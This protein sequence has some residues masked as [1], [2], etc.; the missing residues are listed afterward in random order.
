MT[1]SGLVEELCGIGV[2]M[3]DGG[4]AGFGMPACMRTWGFLC[5]LTLWI[6]GAPS[7]TLSSFLFL[8]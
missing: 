7:S 6:S 2:K 3:V 5:V 1:V 4:K 8:C